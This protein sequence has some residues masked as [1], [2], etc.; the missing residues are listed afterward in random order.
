MQIRAKLGFD[1][2]RVKWGKPD[3]LPA[4]FCSYCGKQFPPKDERAAGFIPVIFWNKS[5]HAAE[6]CTDCQKEWFGI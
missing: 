6:F 1:W 2:N 5:G 3:E 4:E